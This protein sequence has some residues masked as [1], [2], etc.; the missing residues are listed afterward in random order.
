MP[1]A[2]TYGLSWPLLKKSDRR[3]KELQLERGPASIY[4]LGHW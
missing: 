4:I 1:A 2:S 3:P